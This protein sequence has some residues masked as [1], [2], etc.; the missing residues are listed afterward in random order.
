M[1]EVLGIS[2]R[3]YGLIV[4]GGILVGA[5]VA[6]KMVE[7]EGEDAE[8]VWDGLMWVVVGGLVGARLYHVV[9]FWGY[10][11]ANPGRMLAIWNGGVGIFGA[12]LGGVV[13][14]S[15]Y[16]FRV[17]KFSIFNPSAD[18]GQVFQFSEARLFL[19]RLL[20]FLD[21]AA[22]GIPV[23]QAI[24]RWGNFVNQELYGP[25]TDLPWGIFIEEKYRL[26]GY[27]NFTR[28]HPLFLYESVLNLGLALV[29]WRLYR[30][31]VGIAGKKIEVG[32]GGFFGAYLAGYGV[33]RFLLEFMRLERWSWGSIPVAQVVSVGMIVVGL[34]LIKLNAQSLNVKTKR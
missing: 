15:I 23:S 8:L 13:G 17:E 32:Q 33:I 27:E 22:F 26:P 4:G 5:W 10:Y 21:V 9:D 28:F 31:G 30:Q 14:L 3:L 7:K 16:I 29:L 24:G 12:L 11:Q 25:P 20:W 2:L 19:G 34:V 18:S 1:I 6:A